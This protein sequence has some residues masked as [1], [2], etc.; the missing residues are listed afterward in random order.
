MS[1]L[2]S[3][4]TDDLITMTTT[5]KKRGGNVSKRSKKSE[6]N[7]LVVAAAAASTTSLPANNYFNNA[8]LMASC[9]GCE[10]PILDQYVYNVLDLTWHQSCIQCNDCKHNLMDKCFSREGKLFCKDDFFR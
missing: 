10:R 1:Q 4:A 7:M 2:R 9:A 3:I 6:L 8:L 5:G